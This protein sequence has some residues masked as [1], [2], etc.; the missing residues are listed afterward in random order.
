MKEVDAMLRAVEKTYEKRLSSIE[1]DFWTALGVRDKATFRITRDL[2]YLTGSS[3]LEPPE[4]YLS[5]DNL[6]LRHGMLRSDG[7]PQSEIG[8]RSLRTLVQFEIISVVTPGTKRSVNCRGNPTRY[9][10]ALPSE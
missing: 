8:A 10:W 1:R 2:A 5:G 4:F 3:A 6:A 7:N 9:R